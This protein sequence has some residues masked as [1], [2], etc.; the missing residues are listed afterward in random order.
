MHN[1]PPLIFDPELCVGA[2]AH[3]QEM[4][5]KQQD[6]VQIPYSI[7][8]TDNFYNFWQDYLG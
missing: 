4:A 1:S 5:K 8:Y 7:D 3:A 6:R 2:E